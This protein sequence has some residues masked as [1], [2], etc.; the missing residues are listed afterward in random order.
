MV[1]LWTP[2]LIPTTTVLAGF[3]D[4]PESG[5]GWVKANV[6]TG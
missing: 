1:L 2:F 3:N 6:I 4:D 5:S